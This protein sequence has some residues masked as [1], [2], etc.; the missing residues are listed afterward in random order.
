M[1][2]KQLPKEAVSQTVTGKFYLTQNAASG[3]V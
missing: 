2:L 3:T 1:I